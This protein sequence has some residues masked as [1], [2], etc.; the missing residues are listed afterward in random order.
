MRRAKRSAVR[1]LAETTTDFRERLMGNQRAAALWAL[2]LGI[3][4]FGASG[5]A[6]GVLGS[7][8]ASQK[9]FCEHAS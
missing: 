7:D 1:A 5:V 6:S 4:A 8:V 2:V 3:G 9:S